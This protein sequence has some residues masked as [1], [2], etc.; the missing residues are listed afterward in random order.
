MKDYE[1]A[2]YGTATMSATDTAGTRIR[3]Y[4]QNDGKLIGVWSWD[5]SLGGGADQHRNAVV[6]VLRN[7]AFPEDAHIIAP[8]ATVAYKK[9]KTDG[10]VFAVKSDAD[11]M[12]WYTEQAR[13]Q[14]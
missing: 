12:R 11:F 14:N 9:P 1:L 6:E 5:H 7:T 13:L 2:M 10:Y 8:V 4:R 3:V